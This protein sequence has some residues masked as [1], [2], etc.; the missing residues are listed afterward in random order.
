MKT[1][2]KGI[3]ISD[4]TI[5]NLKGYLSNSN[6]EPRI[7]SIL[8]PFNQVQ[9]VLLDTQ[10]ECWAAKP[11][12]AII[13]CLPERIIPSFGK[14]SIET[15]LQETDEFIDLL[16]PLHQ[17]VKFTLIASFAID[18]GRFNGLT[19]LK[20]KT[21]IENIL[22]QMNLRMIEKLN[23]SQGFY[24]L[25]SQRWIASSGT[26]AFQPKLWYLSKNP[27]HNSVFEK[28]A[29]EI[30]SSVRGILGLSKKMI[31]VDLDDTLW[32]G[33]LGD[34]GWENLILGGHDALGEAYVDFQRELKILADKGILIAIVSKNE[35]KTA[36][37]AIEKHPEMILRK[38]NIAAWRINWEDKAKNITELVKELRLGLD[39]VVFIDDNP[40]ERARVSESLPDI[41]V[42]EMPA[43]KLFYPAFLRS[44][45]C[46]N[47]PFISQEDRNRNLLYAEEKNRTENRN[48]FQ[49]L[50]EWLSGIGIKIKAERVSKKNSQRVTQLLNKTNQLNLRTRRMTEQEILDWD[51]SSD[52]FMW[53]FSTS[54]RFGDAGLTGIISISVKGE[55]AFIADFILSCRVI[56]RKTEETMLG[57]ANLQAIKNKC[58]FLKAEYLPT[59]KN[60]PCFLFFKGSGMRRKDNTF[61]WDCTAEFKI[62]PYIHFTYE[63]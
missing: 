31:I 27:F 50:D 62:P 2:L 19:A 43:D 33:I 9:Q 4:F 39:S 32:G 6:S 34:I 30:Q 42:P 53:A 26:L 28:A 18:P 10:L 49:S 47:K 58:L 15:V 35:E 11:D 40:V 51:A 52:N 8:A 12:F 7:E 20:S 14:G 45:N 57:F 29:E 59:D 3:L 22:M 36:L 23:E 17:R 54:D 24:L 56:G 44:L 63:V 55:T 13:W 21:G 60:N 5:N 37:A 61:T 16:K 38:K 41:F 25:D 46:F 1:T 48:S